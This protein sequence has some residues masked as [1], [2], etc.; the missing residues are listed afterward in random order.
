MIDS[1]IGETHINTVLSAIDIPPVCHNTSKKC[2][3]GLARQKSM[4]PAV[5][6]ELAKD[7]ESHGAYLACLV[8]DDDASTHKRVVE[9]VGDVANH[10]DIGHVKCGLSSKLFEAKTKTK[11]M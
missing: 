1:R 8:G 4:E 5:A 7:L 3:R 10:S 6:V 2:E 11:K 9:E